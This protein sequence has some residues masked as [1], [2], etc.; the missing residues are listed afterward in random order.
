MKR[1][2]RPSK[3]SSNLSDSIHQQLNMYALAAS[4][5]GVGILAL[6]QPAEAKIVYTPAHVKFGNNSAIHIDLNHDGINDFTLQDTYFRTTGNNAWQL[7]ASVARQGNGIWGQNSTHS[8]G[9]LASALPAGVVIRKGAHSFLP[10]FGLM[11]AVGA[12][13]FNST[14]CSGPWNNVKNRYLGLKFLIKGKTHFGWARL[15]VSCSTKLFK[16]AGVLTG[17]AYETV[18]NKGIIAGKTKG[19]D[20]TSNVA[21]PT[22]AFLTAPTPK[23]ATLGLLAMGAPGLSVW[24]REESAGATQ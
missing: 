2:P 10:D 23:L 1:S 8:R 5:T 19:S 21:Q 14:A 24:R 3:V 11:A 16:V 20:D 18:A 13:K 12:G 17:Y 22:S 4:A 6:A 15:N 9:A 7:W